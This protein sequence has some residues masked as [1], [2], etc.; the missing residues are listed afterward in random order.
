MLDYQN[1]NKL[2]KNYHVEEE[3]Y[4]KRIGERKKLGP[5]FKKQVFQ[6]NSPSKVIINKEER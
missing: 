2:E 5:R 1:K 6:E 4:E 3:V